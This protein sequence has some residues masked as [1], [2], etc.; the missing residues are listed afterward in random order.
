MHELSIAMAVIS[1]VE[2][3]AA[4]AG[5]GRVLAV[6]LRIGTFS[7]VDPTA[8]ANCFTLA[9]EGTPLAAARLEIVEVPLRIWCPACGVE[10]DL[11]RSRRLICP[12]CGG[13]SGDIRGGRELDLESFELADTASPP[14]DPLP[15]D[16]S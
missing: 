6:T 15:G 4:R 16:A 1:E 14:P 11:L 3:R 2:R 8:L 7:G 9:G 13:A 12:E 5:G 10:R